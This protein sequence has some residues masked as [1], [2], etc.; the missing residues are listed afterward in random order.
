MV[1]VVEVAGD[2]G[3]GWVCLAKTLDLKQST[4]V[5]VTLSPSGVKYKRPYMTTLSKNAYV[6]C[7]PLS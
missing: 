4:V 5:M 7:L 2:V 1:H 6:V 3:G